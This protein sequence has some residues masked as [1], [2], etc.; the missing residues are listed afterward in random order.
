VIVNSIKDHSAGTV[1]ETG[2][3]EV[4][5]L[6]LGAMGASMAQALIK[7]GKR[8]AIWNRSPAKAELLRAAG[9]HFCET[10]EAA[11]MASPVSIVVLL[12]QDA[13]NDVF[14]QVDQGRA[15]AGRTIVNFTTNSRD[16]SAALG[17][18]VEEAG[19]RFVKGA[20]IAYPRNIGHPETFA[21][22]SGDPLAVSNCSGVLKLI[23]PNEVILPLAE[24]YA[25]SVTL[26][27]FMFSAMAA[28]YESVRASQHF[29]QLPAETAKLIQ[30]VSE[31]FVTDALQDAVRRLE[32]GDFSGDQARLDVHASAFEYLAKANHMSG[33]Q[34]PI[35]EAVCQ[36]ITQAQEMGLGNEDI[37]AMTKIITG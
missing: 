1:R 2:Q 37:V 34:I 36:T 14:D 31:Y 19:G 17:R 11:I 21:I 6:G 8:V 29:G 23:A 22:Y 26:H 16:E 20:I 13:V 10:A 30:K 18:L 5:V 25:F 9:A 3:F 7:Q 4:S 33:A 35:F 24:A 32:I 15:F 28:F 12:D 27:S